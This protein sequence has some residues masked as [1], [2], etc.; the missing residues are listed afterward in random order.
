MTWLLDG[1]ALSSILVTRLR[2][3]GDVVMSTVVLDVLKQ[4]DPNVRLG[5]L[6]ESPFDQ[7]LK[8]HPHVDRLFCLA[9]PRAGIG[10][11]NRKV[12]P[13][14]DSGGQGALSLLRRLHAEQFDLAIDL[15]F[16]PRS[17]LLLKASGIPA[18]IG[19]TRSSRRILYS[20]LVTRDD[21][22]SF[23]QEL[24]AMAPGGLGDHLCRLA[25]L[26]HKESG[27]SFGDW[28]VDQRWGSPLLP[29]LPVPDF[30]FES[31]PGLQNL[32]VAQDKPYFVLV[33]GATW[34]SKE[35]PPERWRELI[36]RLV[37]ERDEN[38]LI[39]VPPGRVSA[40]SD[41]GAGIPLGRGRVLPTLDLHTVMGI[42]AAARGVISVDGGIM[43]SAVGLGVPTIALFGPTEPEL[44]FPYGH[45]SRFKVL[46]HRLPCQ[47]CHLHICHGF[48]CLPGISADEVMG[49]LPGILTEV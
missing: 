44:W 30:Q 43:H 23:A 6:C 32:E 24:S 48:S 37:Q 18:R 49:A 17:A 36:E 33:P 15:F 4:G 26:Q 29:Q 27:K 10:A 8:G 21:A 42:L 25:P 12:H 7:I 9:P 35:W 19:G 14:D 22:R 41:L 28:L 5:F 16:N 11:G 20:H 1:K 13:H 39:L 40:W 45:D 2:Y 38:L 47:P 46:G 3:L 31:L 34:S